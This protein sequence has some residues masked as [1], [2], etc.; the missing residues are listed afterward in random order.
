[1]TETE[2]VVRY[3]KGRYG[4]HNTTAPSTHAEAT[5]ASIMLA[6]QGYYVCVEKA[7]ENQDGKSK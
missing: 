7:K 4:G 2:W 6:G 1:M 3:R 5:R